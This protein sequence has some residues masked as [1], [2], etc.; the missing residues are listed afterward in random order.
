MSQCWNSE[1]LV[2]KANVLLTIPQPQTQ[3][4]YL[5]L[6]LNCQMQI[7]SIGWESDGSSVPAHKLPAIELWGSLDASCKQEEEGRQNPSDRPQT[8]FIL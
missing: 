7:S 8:L 2:Q 6:D 1:L 3:F 5:K 4:L